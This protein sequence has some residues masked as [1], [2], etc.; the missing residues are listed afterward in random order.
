MFG[1]P[2]IIEVL[3]IVNQFSM[4]LLNQ[5]QTL[6]DCFT[7]TIGT[8]SGRRPHFFA[9]TE[10]S[11]SLCLTFLS[12]FF[13]RFLYWPYFSIGEDLLTSIVCKME[14]WLI[15]FVNFSIGKL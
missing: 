10:K 6:I 9:H 5:M 3:E 12:R 8:F 1:I 2:K 7:F 4:V 15:P 13:S 14:L 11:K